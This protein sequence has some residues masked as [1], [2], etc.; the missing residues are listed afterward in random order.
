MFGVAD[1]RARYTEREAAYAVVLDAER[2]AAVVRARSGMFLPGGGIE[3]DESAEEALLRESLE[4]C[5]RPLEIIGTIGQAIQYCH[6][7]QGP[8]RASHRFFEARFL[9]S[10]SGAGEYPLSWVHI[11]EACRWFRY[12]SHVWAVRTLLARGEP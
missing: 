7:E 8:F 11:D 12:E 3:A 10:A 4:E 6:G 9:G 1:R 2:R 5:G